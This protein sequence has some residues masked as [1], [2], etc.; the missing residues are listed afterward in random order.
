[1]MQINSNLN[2]MV[3]LEKR[4]DTS[5]N[6]VAQSGID[7]SSVQQAQSINENQKSTDQNIDLAHEMVEQIEIP[8]AYT[9]NAEVISVQNDIDKTI[10]DIK[11]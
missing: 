8:I 7:Q 5:A 1:M 10:I 6:A 11:A 4:L 3:H 2:T 9:A